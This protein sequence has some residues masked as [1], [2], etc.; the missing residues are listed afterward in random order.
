MRQRFARLGAQAEG[1]VGTRRGVLALFVLALVVFAVQGIGWRVGG[2]R[3]LGT[4]LRYYLMMWESDP[5]FPQALLAR[6]P[7]TPVVAGVLLDLGGEWL[8]E[9]AMALLYAGSIVAWSSAALVAG[10]RVALATAVAL[11]LFPSYGALFREL[12]TDALF[13][14]GLAGWAVLASRAARRPSASRFALVGAGVA[15]LALIRP[16]SQ[17]LLVAVLLPLLVA[18]SARE[19]VSRALAFTAAAVVGLLAWASVNELR[20]DDFTVAR[21]AQSVV[22]LFRAFA[23]DRIVEPANGPAS[24][25]LADAVRRDLLPREPYRSYGID[26]DEF[27]SSRSGRMHEDLIGLSDRVFGWDS[28]YEVLGRVG[29][30]AV[31]AHPVRYARG[32][33]RSLWQ[34]LHHPLLLPRG[35]SGAIAGGGGSSESETIVVEGRRLPKPSEGQPIPAAHQS[36]FVSRPDVSAREVWTSPTEHH[37]EFDD[38]RDAPRYEKLERRLDELLGRLPSRSASGWLHERLNEAA[39]VYPR[40]WMWLLVGFAALVVRRPAAW[41]VPVVLAGSGLVLL[42]ATVLGVYAVPEYAVPVAPAFILLAFTGLLAP[43]SAP[44]ASRT[45]AGAT[46]RR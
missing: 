18:G 42:L 34:E 16:S 26:L 45:N 44:V 37:L 7:V 1:L 36:G 41:R 17:A 2:G 38:P 30:E 24:R 28:D 5:L 32:V 10:R 31:R 40:S 14:A 4:Y 23:T 29:R 9:L 6:T 15:G 21:G 33:G 8:V 39:R 13:A 27:F 43:R 12:S 3:D 20:Y 35:G 22:P 19:R 11:M 25:E 46:G